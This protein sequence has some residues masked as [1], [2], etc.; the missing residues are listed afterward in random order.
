MQRFLLRSRLWLALVL[1]VVVIAPS[2]GQAA[3]AVTPTVDPARIEAMFLQGIEALQK[4]HPE[5]A[6][7]LF[8]KILAN[9]PSLP[10]VRLEMARAYFMAS[11]WTESKEQFTAVLS[12]D[13]PDAVRLNIMKFIRAIDAR[14]GFDWDLSVAITQPSAAARNYRSDEV[15]LTLYGQPTP[16]H[17]QRERRQALALAVSGQ[18]EFRYSV[19]ALSDASREAVGFTQIS[20][21]TERASV[22]DY[23][24]DTLGGA[25]GIRFSWPQTTLSLSLNGSDRFYGND[26]FENRYWAAGYLEYRFDNGVGLYSDL[27]VG[28]VDDFFSD[29]RDGDTWRQTVGGYKSFGA[30]TTVNAGVFQENLN[31][32]ESF[33]T[34]TETGL[35]VRYLDYV[36]WGLTLDANTSLSYRKYD[37]TY[38][39]LTTDRNDEKFVGNVRLLKSDLFLLKRFN[40][41]VEF[42]GSRVISGTAAFSYDELHLSAGLKKAF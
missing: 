18:G 19:D 34:Y 25:S 7:G 31:A 39:I 21:R 37:E 10:R 2:Q 15:D 5:I 30:T 27:Q 9:D 6:I 36:G 29:T 28:Y 1:A 12:D 22:A 11:E 33:E 8:A 35:I 3:S 17:M 41:Y 40:P 42:S 32:Q 26:H 24:D 20:V 16:F 14:S 13:V 4:G 38:P 23:N